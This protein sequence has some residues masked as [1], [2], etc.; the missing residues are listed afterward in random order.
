VRKTANVEGRFH[1]TRHTLVTDLA[2]SGAGDEVIRDM[3]GHVSK[4]MIK[5]YSHIRIQAKRQAVKALVVAKPSSVQ[6][7]EQPGLALAAVP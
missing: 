7:M 5:H 4:D 3:A 6:Q 2:E 1:D